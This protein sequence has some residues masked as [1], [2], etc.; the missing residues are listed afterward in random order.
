[1]KLRH[2]RLC[3]VNPVTGLPGQVPGEKRYVP[4][5]PRLA[6]KVLI[7]CHP[8]G[9]LP[10]HQRGSRPAKNMCVY[11]LSFLRTLAGL[12]IRRQTPLVITHSSGSGESPRTCDSQFLGWNQPAPY[13]GLSGPS[14]PKCR[15]SLENVS[16]GLRE[17]R[18]SPESLGNSPKRLFR[19]FPETLWRLPRLFPGLLETFQGPGAGGP[20]RHFRH[21]GPEGPERPL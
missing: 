2:I 3:P 20:G 14:G 12:A 7:P 18:K 21:F 15:K 8:A 17:P 1:M 4:W 16:R 11:V 5:V 19:H 13:R 9:R 6:H 10:P